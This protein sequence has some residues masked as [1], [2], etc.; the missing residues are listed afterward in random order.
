MK[1][2]LK[3]HTINPNIVSNLRST[4]DTVKHFVEIWLHKRIVIFVQ[5]KLLDQKDPQ[6]FFPLKQCLGKKWEM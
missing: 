2:T 1:T 6:L 3:V 4:L 5:L